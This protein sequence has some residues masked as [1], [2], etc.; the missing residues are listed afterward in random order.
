[1]WQLIKYRV[2]QNNKR[3]QGDTKGDIE[4]EFYELEKQDLNSFNNHT[5]V[6]KNPFDR[7]KAWTGY[8]LFQILVQIFLEYLSN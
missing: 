7:I 4:K 5:H 6:V 8:P 2:S 1:M 3:V